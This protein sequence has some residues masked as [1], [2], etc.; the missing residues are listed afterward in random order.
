MKIVA[1]SYFPFKEVKPDP[2][3][4]NQLATYLRAQFSPEERLALYAR[5]KRSVDQFEVAIRRAI[6]K[7][8]CKGMGDDVFISNDVEIRNPEV[9]EF[10]THIHISPY[11]VLQAWW[12]GQVKIGDNVW[13]G[14]NVF[15]DGKNLTLVGEIGIGPG[16]VFIGSQHTGV[17][18]DIPVFR[19]DH[20]I[21][22]IVVERG[23]D[24][25]A[26][27]VI[28]S[29]VTIGENAIVGAGSMVNRDVPPN[30]TVAGVPARVIKQRG[31]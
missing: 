6:L 1:K 7:S 4:E 20:V 9:V 12:K 5:Y 8:L 17:P 22:P 30:S 24:I 29:G 28:L 13:I 26:N 10:G 3:F 18:L 2:D 23:V 16:V 19:T 14:S 15:I 31:A 21:E 11:V 27:S 25:G